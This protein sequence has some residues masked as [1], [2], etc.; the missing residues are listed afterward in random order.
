MKQTFFKIKAIFLALLFLVAT[1][2]YAVSSHFCG[3]YLVDVSYLG[4]ADSCAMELVIDD[5]DNDSTYKANC[6]KETIQ[7]LEIDI[8]S[9]LNQN[10]I[11]VFT[12]HFF[13]P[14]TSTYKL[15]DSLVSKEYWFPKNTS[16]P[17]KEINYQVL[18][19]SFLI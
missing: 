17:K 1:N 4:K 9:L 18:F 6:C 10:T 15:N 11:K 16:P 8:E 19:Q 3:S 12:A 2:T 7:L 13:I 5:C 14:L